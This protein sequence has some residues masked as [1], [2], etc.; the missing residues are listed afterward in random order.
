MN[1]LL[2]FFAIPVAIIILSNTMANIIVAKITE[3]IISKVII[4]SPFSMF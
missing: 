4:I 2:I 3:K 1:V